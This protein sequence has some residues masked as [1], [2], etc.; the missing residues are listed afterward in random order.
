MRKG[1]LIIIAGI[2]MGI[3]VSAQEKTLNIYSPDLRV[4]RFALNAIDSITTDDADSLMLVCKTDGSVSSIVM[5]G[6]DSMNFSSGEYA[7]PV[8]ETVSAEYEHSLGKAVCILNTVVPLLFK[9]AKRH[10]TY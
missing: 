7:L 2:W 6:V 10:C 1:V 3:P 4:Q 9:I 5:A 8:V